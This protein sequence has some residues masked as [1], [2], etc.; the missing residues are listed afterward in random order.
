MTTLIWIV[1]ALVA[2]F[3][4]GI[5]IA[6]Y[7]RTVEPRLVTCPD[8][9]SQRAVRVS[10]GSRLSA[11][12]RGRS[13]AELSDCSRWPEKAHC[14]QP[15]RTQI[16][17]APDGCRVQS[18]LHEVYNDKSCVVCHREL[19]DNIDWRMHKPGLLDPSGHV[20]TWM[21][22]PAQELPKVLATHEALCWDCTMV[23]KVR[24]EHPD[25]VTE[26]PARHAKA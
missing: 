1:A 13:D 11:W 24:E 22:F 3:L 19:G 25:A 5:A 7:R 23:Q 21:D 20:R 15:C 26:R 18:M 4:V 8:D 2:L 10:A 6:R 9:Y 16:A 12:L 17:E 14:D